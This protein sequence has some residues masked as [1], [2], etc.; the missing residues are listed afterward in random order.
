[1]SYKLK[2]FSAEDI[3]KAITMDEA[4]EAVRKA[5]KQL[6]IGKAVVPPRI[7]LEIPEY[8]TTALIMSAYLP[9]NKQ[10]GLK[11]INLCENNPSRNLPLAYAIVIVSDA[12]NGIPIAIM[13]GSYLT[14]LRTG[15]ASG[16]A[17][18]IL[19]RKDSKKVAIF[20]AGIQ[21]RTQ[22][23]AV[24]T[25]RNIEKAFI[26]DLNPE[27]AKLFKR[28]MDKKL[29]I[30]IEI[31]ESIEVISEVDIICTATTS[32]TPV[33]PDKYIKKGVHINAIGSYK[34]NVREIPGET[35]AR[36]KV[37]VDKYESCLKEAGDLIIPLKQ[38]LI[39]EKHIHAE[40]GEI[41]AGLKPGR[42]SYEEITFFKSVGNAVQDL[43]VSSLVLSKLQNETFGL[44]IQL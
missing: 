1:M 30:E 16:V 4:I 3:K 31:G 6:S 11:L 26:F 35:I 41:I 15:A 25:V 8:K 34:P 29:S 44:E 42:T 40:I 23:E 36:A 18:D 27:K 39:N 13:D 28:E 22:L 38:K 21:G 19:S 5:F 7:N 9:E 2:I 20:G 12:I 37:V 32:K 14:A 33:F 10:I 43:A 17:T 24:C